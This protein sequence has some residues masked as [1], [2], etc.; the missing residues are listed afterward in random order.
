MY[1]RYWIN[2]TYITFPSMYKFYKAQN[3]HTIFFKYAC[4]V[5]HFVSNKNVFLS[6]FILTLHADVTCLCLII[7]LLRTIWA[8]ICRTAVL[9]LF[10]KFLLSHWNFIILSDFNKF[11]YSYYSTLINF[12]LLKS[13][14]GVLV[15]SVGV[16]DSSADTVFE[17][18]L[19]LD[20]HQRYE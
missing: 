20:R 15:K 9:L 17:V 2:L 8:H 11:H 19:N 10:H 6:C 18:I 1:A 5:L 4:F 12:T 16:I 3:N 14:R 7:S 13:D